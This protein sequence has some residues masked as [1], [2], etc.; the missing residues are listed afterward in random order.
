MCLKPLRQQA[1]RKEF[2][3]RRSPWCVHPQENEVGHFVPLRSSTWTRLLQ[4]T[5]SLRGHHQRS[6]HIGEYIIHTALF[7][8]SENTA[9]LVCCSQ[10]CLRHFLSVSCNFLS[11]GRLRLLVLSLGHQN[12]AFLP[13]ILWNLFRNYVIYFLCYQLMFWRLNWCSKRRRF[14]RIERKY[15]YIMMK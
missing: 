11:S 12:I 6:L 2:C 10:V 8:S 13:L 15:I 3:C 9:R 4:V 5:C 7:I 1:W 14:L